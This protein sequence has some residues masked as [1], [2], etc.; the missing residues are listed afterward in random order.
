MVK[1]PALGKQNFILG[2]IIIKVNIER[3]ER[4]IGKLHES[5]FTLIIASMVTMA[6]TLIW[7]GFLVRFA[8]G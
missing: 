1:L 7:V 8:V 6:L 5:C 3:L 4:V 2:L